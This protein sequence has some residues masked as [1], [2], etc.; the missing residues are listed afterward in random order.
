MTAQTRPEAM[1]GADVD[2]LRMPARGFSS[3]SG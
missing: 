3:S 2:G 1:A